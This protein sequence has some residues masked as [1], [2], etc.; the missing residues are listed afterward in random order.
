MRNLVIVLGDQ[1]HSGS[2]AFEGFD[3]S[4]DAVWMA[5]VRG[6]GEYVWSHKAR[7]ALFLSAMRHFRE[8]LRGSGIT[9]RYIELDAPGNSGSL[10]E[11]LKKALSELQPR[12][13][14]VTLPGEWRVREDLRRGARE[15]GVPLEERPDRHFLC[16]P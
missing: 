12:K 10:G 8:R 9:V 7:I 16:S 14:I 2:S 5:E 15:A 1:L 4:R 3:A 11:E 13:A 6:E